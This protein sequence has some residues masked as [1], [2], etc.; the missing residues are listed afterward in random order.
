MAVN[1]PEQIQKAAWLM[2]QV[3]DDVRAKMTSSASTNPIIGIF[4]TTIKLAE[5]EGRVR[6]TSNAG[7]TQTAFPTETMSLQ[8][9]QAAQ[10]AKTIAETEKKIQKPVDNA[11]FNPKPQR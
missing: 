4:Q 5:I 3:S 8:N 2:G 11:V 6:A 1:S 10:R 9:E 7:L